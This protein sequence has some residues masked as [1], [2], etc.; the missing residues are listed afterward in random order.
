MIIYLR[1]SEYSPMFTEP[2]VNNCFSKTFRSEYQGVQNDRLKHKQ[3]SNYLCIC[4]W[5]NYDLTCTLIAVN[6]HNF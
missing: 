6:T 3:R 5:F 2:E 4:I 1:L